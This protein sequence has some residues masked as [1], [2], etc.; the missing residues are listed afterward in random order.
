M[1]RWR[2]EGPSVQGFKASLDNMVRPCP[3]REGRIER[4]REGGEGGKIL[5]GKGGGREDLCN[6]FIKYPPQRSQ[7]VAALGRDSGPSGKAQAVTL[8]PGRLST[9]VSPSSQE[10]MI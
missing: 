2:K 9:T 4:R 6:L 7:Q 1:V 8:A 3:R 5:G 10:L